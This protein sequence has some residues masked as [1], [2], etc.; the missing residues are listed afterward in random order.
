MLTRAPTRCPVCPRICAARFIAAAL[1]A[2]ALVLGC[3]QPDAGVAA[4]VPERQTGSVGLEGRLGVS[5]NT[6]HYAIL[7][8]AFEPCGTGRAEPRGRT[9]RVGVEL[10]LRR[11]GPVQVPANPYYA[12]LVGPDRDVH[13]ATLGGCGAPLAPALPAPGQSAQGWVVFEVPRGGQ[14]FTLVYDPELVEV[15]EREVTIA[16][17]R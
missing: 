13:E 17:E 11:T 3:Q 1:L 5:V 6:E 7:A 9:Q 10:S 4:P 12:T 2:P 16:L 15:P 14:G 8:S